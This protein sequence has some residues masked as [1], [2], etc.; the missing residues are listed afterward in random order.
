MTCKGICDSHKESQFIR[1]YAS[2]AKYCAQCRFWNTTTE[3][4]CFCCH[5]QYRSS[6]RYNPKSIPLGGITA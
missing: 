1:G 2:G 5:Q 4:R 3:L 6:K